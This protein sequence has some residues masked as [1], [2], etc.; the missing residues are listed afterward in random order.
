MV[1]KPVITTKVLVVSDTQQIEPLLNSGLRDMGLD[2]ITRPIPANSTSYWPEEIPDL[3][4]IDSNA[5]DIQTLELIKRFRNEASIP[6]LLLIQHSTEEFLLEAYATGVDECIVKPL[7]PLLFYAK[8]RVWLRRSWSVPADTLDVLRVGGFN[9]LPSDRIL[10]FEGHDPI[11]LTN[12]ELRLL[13]CLMSQ[14]GQTIT[15]EKLNLRVWGYCNEV[16]NTMLKNVVYRLRR[17]I[18]RK[19][20]FPT[21]LQTVAGVGYKFVYQDVY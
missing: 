7:N 12:L 4:V 1:S 18:E 10:V 16:D 5:P 17:K 3:V 13:Y 15:I 11:R 2:V 6:L 9:L 14:P 21:I 20:A 8:V 19:P